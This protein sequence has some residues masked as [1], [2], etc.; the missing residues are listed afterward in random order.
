MIIT[1]EK[2]IDGQKYRYT[3]SDEGRYVVRNGV[4]YGD[5]LDPIDS[6]REYTEG[7]LI[8]LT[9]TELKAKAYDIM[10]GVSE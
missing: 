6:G 5:A 2:I 10:T 7:E 9:E 3:Y 1:T 8:G 4:A